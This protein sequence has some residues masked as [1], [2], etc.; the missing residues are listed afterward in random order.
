MEVEK[1]KKTISNPIKS[2]AGK[3]I[4]AKE[5]VPSDQRC[6]L[7]YYED[8]NDSGFDFASWDGIHWKHDVVGWKLSLFEVKYWMDIPPIP[9]NN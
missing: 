1:I 2:I 8:G 5:G 9:Q 4:E 7:V 3:W 6:V